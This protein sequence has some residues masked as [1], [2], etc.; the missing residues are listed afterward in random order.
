MVSFI[1]LT[2]YAKKTTT[3]RNSA[4]KLEIKSGGEFS[5]K[6]G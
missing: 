2:L 6:D 5:H 1:T 4:K 3:K